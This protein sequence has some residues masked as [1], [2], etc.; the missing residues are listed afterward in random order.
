MRY[1]FVYAGACALALLAPWLGA[2]PAVVGGG[3]AAAP[4]PG[5]PTHFE[6]RP[7]TRLPLTELE[8]R[9]GSDFPG[10]M[11]RFTDGRRELV[12]RF[13]TDATRKLHPASDCFVAIG[14]RVRPLPLKV[15]AGGSRWGSFTAERGGERLLVNERIYSDAGGS[16]E[17]ASAWY[18]AAVGGRDAGPWWAVTVAERE[19]RPDA[20]GADAR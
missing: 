13:V 17:D 18:W 15:D 16:W 8:E 2:A 19:A 6:G 12:V 20:G 5:W 11:A 10:R 1:T 14:Y 9:F 7:L 4:F 3:G